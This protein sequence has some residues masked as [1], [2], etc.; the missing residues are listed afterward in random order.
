MRFEDI[1]LEEVELNGDGSGDFN[2]PAT[3]DLI[4]AM[5]K[6]RSRNGNTDLVG[7]DYDN[8]VYY[9][10]YLVFQPDERDITIYATS[11]NGEKDDFVGYSNT[12][13]DQE[14]EMLMWKVIKE[15]AKGE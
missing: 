12:L 6:I 3:E 15:L 10:F 13:T 4:E 11:N 9:N 5:N 1:E 14:R 7:V 2:I 8:D